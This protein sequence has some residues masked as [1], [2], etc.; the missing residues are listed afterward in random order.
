MIGKIEIKDKQISRV[1]YLPAYIPDDFAPYIVK[2]GD[3]LFDT[4][5][6]YMRKINDMMDIDIRYT[7][8]GDEVVI[9][10]P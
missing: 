8:D 3:P 9:S 10:A 1:S 6:N 5:N 4:I 2:A 7:V